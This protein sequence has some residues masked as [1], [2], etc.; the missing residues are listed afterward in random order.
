MGT[1]GFGRYLIAGTSDPADRDVDAPFELVFASSFL[2]A[3][4]VGPLAEP[5]T[6]AAAAPLAND[7]VLVTGGI[8]PDTG[9]V[10]PSGEVFAVEAGV[11]FRFDESVRLA[12]P[13]WG[14][15]ATNIGGDRILL[16][17]GFSAGGQGLTRTELFVGAP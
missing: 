12:T 17:G 5:R 16:V 6:D 10:R 3:L 4:A 11:F 13:R 1:D 8:G 15:T 7:L 2:D 9:T 14:H